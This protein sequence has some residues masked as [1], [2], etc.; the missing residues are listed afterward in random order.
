VRVDGIATPF[1]LQGLARD[2][3]HRL[4]Y[5]NMRC[6]APAMG[7]LMAEHVREHG[8]S[9]DVI[10]SV[11][12]HPR[13]LRDRGYNQAHLLAQAVAEGLGLPIATD[14]L[15][16]VRPTPQQI[17]AGRPDRRA[18]VAN[19]FLAAPDVG[20]LRILLVDDVCTTGATLEAC[21]DAL[22]A[23]GAAKVAGLVFAR[24][25]NTHPDR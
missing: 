14:A 4:K 7:A 3:V 15:A 13:R 20:G 19:A 24:T 1:L 18:N 16:R 2:M 22:R 10:A 23:A 9:A 12:L 17:A 25:A 11:P 5:R 21:A 6:L 8:I